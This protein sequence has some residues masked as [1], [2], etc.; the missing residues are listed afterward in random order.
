MDPFQTF[1][2]EVLEDI[3]KL[4]PD[5]PS[6]HSLHNASPHVASLL[7]HKGNLSDV[8][9]AILSRS[10][11]HIQFLIR[12]VVLLQTY[13]NETVPGP[14]PITYDAFIGV[15]FINQRSDNHRRPISPKYGDIPLPKSTPTS[16]LCRVL[17]LSRRVRQL[18]HACIHSL[19]E[20]SL[21]LRPRHLKDPNFQCS[22]ASTV[23]FLMRQVKRAEYGLPYEPVESGPPCWLE[24]QRIARAVWRLVLFHELKATVVVRNVLPWSDEDVKRLQRLEVDDF[25]DEMLIPT[26]QQSDENKTVSEWIADNDSNGLS[27]PWETKTTPALKKY[28]YCCPHITPPMSEEEICKQMQSFDSGSPGWSEG[29]LHVLGAPHSPLKFGD[30]AFYR[31]YGFAIWESNRMID[32]GF[33]SRSRQDV[34]SSLPVLKMSNLF[35]TWR[36]I[37]TQQQLE[38]LEKKQRDMWHEQGRSD[39]W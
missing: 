14:L 3:L 5:L 2:F 16:V 10:P 15:P 17:E 25:W 31:P 29:T 26:V 24:E 30:F 6:L 36:S 32:L 12:T 35:Y 7:H 18:T 11:R 39:Q 22:Q 27:M 19:I 4:I 8:F 23:D 9:E 38:E 1:P 21:S 37:L 13:P 33:E 28:S 20:R 34:K